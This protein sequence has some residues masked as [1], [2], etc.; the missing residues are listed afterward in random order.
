MAQRD[1]GPPATISVNLSPCQLRNPQLA[2]EVAAALSDSGPDRL[3][4][5]P[6]AHRD[7]ARR[8]RATTHRTVCGPHRDGRPA[9][10]RRLRDRVVV[11]LH[12]RRFPLGVLKIDGSFVAGLGKDQDDLEV[13][14]A[15]LGLGEGLGLTTI[16]EG[17]ETAEQSRILVELGCRY[18]QGYLYGRP[19]PAEELPFVPPGPGGLGPSCR[20]SARSATAKHRPG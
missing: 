10:A 14:R 18:A 17:V 11:A 12:L 4:P 20:R 15:V 3:G 16:A 9:R 7:G 19:V 5:L 13:V 1:P 2:E 8:G 6:G